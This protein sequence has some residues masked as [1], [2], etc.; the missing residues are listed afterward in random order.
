MTASFHS[1][2]DLNYRTALIAGDNSNHHWNVQRYVVQLQMLGISVIAS[3]FL[4][5]LCSSFAWLIGAVLYGG[6]TTTYWVIVAGY[7]PLILVNIS[8]LVFFSFR[9]KTVVQCIISALLVTAATMLWWPPVAIWMLGKPYRDLPSCAAF[10][11]A[12]C[13]SGNTTALS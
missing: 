4:L 13:G 2:D 3:L 6:I 9:H 1:T 10:C 8:I 7:L 12:V 11:D 5:L